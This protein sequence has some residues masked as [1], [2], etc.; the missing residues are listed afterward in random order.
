[1]ERTN[2]LIF[3]KVMIKL[4]QNK[5]INT[6][7]RKNKNTETKLKLIQ[8]HVTWQ[9]HVTL[10]LFTVVRWLRSYFYSY[11]PDVRIDTNFN[12][13]EKDRPTNRMTNWAM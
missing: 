7:L 10:T 13:L 11:Q 8:C 2:Y 12:D 4:R 9:W 3:K 1:M 5:N 6:K